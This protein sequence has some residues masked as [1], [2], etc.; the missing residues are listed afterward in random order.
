[1]AGT[2]VLAASAQ[3]LLASEYPERAEQLQQSGAILPLEQILTEARKQYPGRVLETDL[4]RRHERY[5]YEIKIMDDK[6]RVR[7]LKYDAA[8]GKLLKSELEKS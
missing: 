5:V 3:T 4:E 1:M 7:E 8:T 6:G 2:L